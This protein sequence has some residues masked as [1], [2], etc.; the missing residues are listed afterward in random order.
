MSSN[1]V[2]RWVTL[3]DYAKDALLGKQQRA[4]VGV[5]E[6]ARGM[7]MLL[8]STNRHATQGA[9]RECLSSVMYFR[10]YITAPYIGALI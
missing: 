4:S 6:R 2:I 7:V 9:S 1:P 10:R 3:R 8:T 5:E